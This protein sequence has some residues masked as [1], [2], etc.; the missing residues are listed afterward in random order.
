MKSGIAVTSNDV[1]WWIADGIRRTLETGQ[2]DPEKR[3]HSDQRVKDHHSPGEPFY[4]V[5]SLSNGKAAHLSF[6][7]S[8]P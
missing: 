7:F 8:G 2:G 1:F 3:N 5:G 4:P 6:T